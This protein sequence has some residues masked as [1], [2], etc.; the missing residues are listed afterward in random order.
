MMEQAIN[1]AEN[2]AYDDYDI[3]DMP[4][5]FE[6]SECFGTGVTDEQNFCDSCFG[7]GVEYM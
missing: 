6:C 4:D 2:M 1:M 7:S 3:Y 5:C